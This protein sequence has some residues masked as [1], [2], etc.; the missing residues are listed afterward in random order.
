MGRKKQKADTKG[1]VLFNI[2]YEDGTL[3]SNRKVPAAE[4]GGLDG[5]APARTF[6]E[7]QDQEIA[8]RSGNQ[9]GRIKTIMRADDAKRAENKSKRSEKK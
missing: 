9:R 7:S 5:D 3:S 2:I 1:S 4:L 8:E 6:I